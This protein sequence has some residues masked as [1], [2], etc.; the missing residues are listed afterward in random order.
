LG[1]RAPHSFTPPLS[2]VGVSNNK[3]E[4]G[5]KNTKMKITGKKDRNLSKKREKIE[6]LQKVVEGT[7][8]REGL[9]AWNFTGIS[10]Q[11]NMALRHGK[12]I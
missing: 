6:K 2:V 1:K 12:V 7:S 10:E 4:N 3:N 9:Q 11:H 8:Q 5:K